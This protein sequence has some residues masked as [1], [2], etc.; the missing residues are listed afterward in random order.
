MLTKTVIIQFCLIFCPIFFIIS[1]S[2]RLAP[3]C[4]PKICV[5]PNCR[6]SSSQIP[7][8]LTLNETPQFVLLTFDDAI[9]IGNIEYYRSALTNRTNSDGCPVAATFFVSHEYTDYSLVNL[10]NDLYAILIINLILNQVN[11]IYSHGHEIALHSISHSASTEYWRT[12]NL[13]QMTEEFAGERHLISKFANIP[14]NAIQGIRLPFL[15]MSGDNSFEMLN[16]ENILYDC[17]WPSRQYPGM[18]PYTLDTRSTQ[19]CVIGPCP[20]KQWNG[21]WVLPMVTWL[22][23]RGF[24]CA[25]VDTCGDMYL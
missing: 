8:N 1:A 19:D 12:M 23:N 3:N 20:E 10:K 13:T 24:P 5:P 9:T 21:T 15:Q 2:D 14:L 22:D 16:R 7:G 6:C 25:M 11:Q 4:D 17:S 18:W